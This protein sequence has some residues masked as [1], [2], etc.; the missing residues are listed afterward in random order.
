MSLGEVH[1]P[2]PPFTEAWS[3]RSPPSEAPSLS[4]SFVGVG[5]VGCRGTRLKGVPRGTN[6]ESRFSV[7]TTHGKKQELAQSESFM[8]VQ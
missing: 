2:P 7:V 8:D 4:L 3:Q 1:S 5:G 6:Q